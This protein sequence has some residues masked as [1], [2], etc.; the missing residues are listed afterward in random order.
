MVFN[1]HFL[2]P[3]RVRL[4]RGMN[5]KNS[6]RVALHLGK[7]ISF[8]KPNKDLLKKSYLNTVVEKLTGI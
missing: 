3:K 4:C 5:H 8:S 1:L 2:A 7:G 6:M